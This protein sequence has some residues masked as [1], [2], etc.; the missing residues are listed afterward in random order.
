M[1]GNGV[2]CIWRDAAPLVA[3]LHAATDCYAGCRL[4][5]VPQERPKQ[6]ALLQSRGS[7]L[8]Y[9]QEPRRTTVHKS[10]CLLGLGAS[11]HFSTGQHR[12]QMQNCC[13]FSSPAPL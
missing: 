5:D 1:H 3:I 4:G 6:A 2:E 13:L 8:V 9:K 12:H 11:K 7:L 10:T